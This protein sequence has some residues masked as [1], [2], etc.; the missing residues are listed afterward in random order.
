MF[1][2]GDTVQWKFGGPHMIVLSTSANQATCQWFDKNNAFHSHVFT[3][4]R[5]VKI[6]DS[7]SITVI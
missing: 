1:K 7:P 3:F 5:L 4:D 2:S 6:G